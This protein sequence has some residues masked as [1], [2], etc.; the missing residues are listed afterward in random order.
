M[1]FAKLYSLDSKSAD[2]QAKRQAD[3]RTPAPASK[4]FSN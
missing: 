1:N 4:Q 2:E 3:I